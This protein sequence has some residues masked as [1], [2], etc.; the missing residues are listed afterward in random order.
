M[1]NLSSRIKRLDI[2]PSRLLTYEERDLYGVKYLS[3]Q[4]R[5]IGKLDY[6]INL[7]TF[8]YTDTDFQ[9]YPRCIFQYKVTM[10]E[11]FLI[12]KGLPIQDFDFYIRN[13]FLAVRFN[14]NGVTKRYVVLGSSA[15]KNADYSYKQ[16]PVYGWP[17]IGNTTVKANCVFEFWAKLAD[18]EIGIVKDIPLKTSLIRDPETADE[19]SEIVEIEETYEIADLSVVLPQLLPYT[20]PNHF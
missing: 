14:D 3:A 16:H 9:Y 15:E 10:P 4:A 1:G 8:Y 11:D 12:I 5:K 18:S 13:G 6:F 20:Q 7:P 17:E 2:Y 19:V